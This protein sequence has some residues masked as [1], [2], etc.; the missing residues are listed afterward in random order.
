MEPLDPLEDAFEQ[1]RM[2]QDKISQIE[3]AGDSATDADRA[4]LKRLRGAL[5]EVKREIARLAA[6]DANA[7]PQDVPEVVPEADANEEAANAAPGVPLAFN[8][9]TGLGRVVVYWILPAFGGGVGGACIIWNRRDFGVQ[10]ISSKTHASGG[11]VTNMPTVSMPAD[12]I[13]WYVD[14]KIGGLFRIQGITCQVNNQPIYGDGNNVLEIY[15]SN[16]MNLPWLIAA[17]AEALGWSRGRKQAFPDNPTCAIDGQKI[18]R[19]LW[20]LYLRSGRHHCR[21]CYRTICGS[22]SR[23]LKSLRFCT[24]CIDTARTYNLLK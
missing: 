6:K 12:A 14:L 1:R 18:S 9:N 22:H 16:T 7:A 10:L 4:E 19:S 5:A 13:R 15:S 21:R 11:Q 8:Q 2:L 23:F 20:T 17:K 3:E 24:D